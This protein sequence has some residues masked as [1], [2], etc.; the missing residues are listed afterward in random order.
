MSLRLAAA[1]VALVHMTGIPA[2]NAADVFRPYESTEAPDD[3][4]P[5]YQGGRAHVD[6][7]DYDD[8]DND[9]PRYAERDDYQPYAGGKDW[10]R[11]GE[12]LR[13]MPPP[14]RFVERYDAPRYSGPQ[15]APRHE[16]RRELIRDGWSEFEEVELRDR[17]AV[18]TARRPNGEA[19]RLK[20]DRCSG[21]IV[22]AK[23]LRSTHDSYAWR[24]RGAYPTY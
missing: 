22:A 15:C 3:R 10:D 21:Q 9:A 2:A 5:P 16:I 1:F 14:T 24:R 4:Y 13:P 7:G 12:Y 17:V 23:P 19:Y 18:V 20:I 11:R 8:D 6:N